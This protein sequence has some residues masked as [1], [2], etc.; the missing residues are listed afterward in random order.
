MEQNSDQVNRLCL[1]HA[2]KNCS[3]CDGKFAFKYQEEFHDQDCLLH[4]AQYPCK[5]CNSVQNMS[6]SGSETEWRSVRQKMYECKTCVKY[7][8]LVNDFVTKDMK[9]N[10][11]R[12]YHLFA[13]V[14]KWEIRACSTVRSTQ[15]SNDPALLVISQARIFVQR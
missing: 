3:V 2:K 10:S 12:L 5:V 11:K 4:D 1:Q 6:C 15:T 14:T 8:K 13:A 7:A 9:L